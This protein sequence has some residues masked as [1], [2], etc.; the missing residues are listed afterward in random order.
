MSTLARTTDGERDPIRVLVVDDEAPAAEL[1]E[2]ALERVAE[3]LDVET[4][5]DPAAALERLADGGYDCLV[6]DYHMPGIDGLEV[7]RAARTRRPEVA[8]VLFT[9]DGR[10]AGPAREAGVGFQEKRGRR[11][12]FEALAALIQRR[13]AGKRPRR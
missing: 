1:A 7:C 8:C 10:L 13:V 12:Q 11:G 3:G 4:A 5:T 2:A 6:S 9:S